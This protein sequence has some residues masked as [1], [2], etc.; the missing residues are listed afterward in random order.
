MSYGLNYN[1]IK[2]HVSRFL[3]YDNANLTTQQ[4]QDVDDAI[5]SGYRRFLNPPPIDSAAAHQWS[6]MHT[7]GTLGLVA[8]D[9]EYDAPEDF[10]TLL[11]SMTFVEQSLWRSEI[12][13]VPENEIRRLRMQDYLEAYNYPRYVAIRYTADDPPKTEFLFYPE[14]QAAHTLEYLY[15]RF[16]PPLTGTDKPIGGDVHS[17]TVLAAALASAENLMEENRGIWEA[18]FLERIRTSISHD[19][20][21]NPTWYGYHGDPRQEREYEWPRRVVTI[22][23]ENS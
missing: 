8:N 23:H 4:A 3:G 1:E 9:W 19:R 15:L 7:K 21:N 11:G 6:F 5:Q 16:V 22:T 18:K 13:Q 2:R 14:P 17:E 12:K 20:R 10:G